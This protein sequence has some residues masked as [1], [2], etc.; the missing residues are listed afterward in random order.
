M[1]FHSSPPSNS[2]GTWLCRALGRKS[3]FL[4]YKSDLVGTTST[5]AAFTQSISDAFTLDAS[6]GR[7]SVTA[8]RPPAED[9][10]FSNAAPQSKRPCP[11]AAQAQG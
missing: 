7:P 1:W 9:A 5:A 8:K 4:P 11:S 6:L 10:A 2:A 3:G